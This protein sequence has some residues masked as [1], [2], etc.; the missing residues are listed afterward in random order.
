ML[1]VVPQSFSSA[2]LTCTGGDI[3]IGEKLLSEHK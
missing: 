2:Q 3:I 1:A